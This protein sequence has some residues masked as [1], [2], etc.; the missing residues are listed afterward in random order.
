MRIE[1]LTCGLLM[2]SICLFSATVCSEETGNA[3]FQ[4][5]SLLEVL[6]TF[7]SD[8]YSFIYT[9]DLV[10]NK[11]RV[12]KDP[13]P[14]PPL[15]RLRFILAPHGLALRP[16]S[17]ANRWLVVRDQ[18]WQKFQSGRITDRESGEPLAGVRVEI[19]GTVV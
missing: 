1:S 16:G 19:A 17:V 10:R 8:G 13:P 3:N 18:T 2:T 15:D 7:E 14:G 5:R 12:R 9:S 11:M 6:A 4:G